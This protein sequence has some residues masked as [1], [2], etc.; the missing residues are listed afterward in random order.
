MPVAEFDGR[1]GW[2]YDGVE[3]VRSHATCTARPTISAGSSTRPIGSAWASCWTWSTTISARR[4][5]ISGQFSERATSRGGITPIGAKRSTSTARTRGPVREFFVANAGYWIDEF[6]LDGLRLD[7]VH[8]I[9]DDSTDHVLAAIAPAR[10][11]RRPRGRKTLVIAEN[12]F[13]ESQL[14]RPIERGRLRPRRGLERRLSSFRSRGNDRAQRILLRRLSRYAAGIDFGREVGLSLSRPVERAA[15]SVGAARRRLDLD[16]CQVRRFPAKPRSGRQ[17]A[18]RPALPRVDVAGPTSS[19]DGTVAP[20]ARHAAAC[21]KARNSRPRPVSLFR[22]S[23]RRTLASWCARGGTKSMRQFRRLAGADATELLGRSVRSVRRSPRSKLDLASATSP[24]RRPMAMHRDLLR[25]R[26]RRSESSPPSG[27]IGSTARC[28]PQRLFA[29][30][31]SASTAT[32]ACCWSIWAATASG[33]RRPSHCWCRRPECEWT[34]ALVERRSALWRPGHRPLDDRNWYCAGTCGDGAPRG[35]RWIEDSVDEN[36]GWQNKL[37]PATRPRRRIAAAGRSRCG[38]RTP[39]ST[40]CTSA[41]SSTATTTA[42]AIFA[43]L[44]QKLDYLQDLGVT[45]LWLLPFYPSPLRDDGYD[46]ADYTEINPSYGT[47]R[48]FKQFVREAHVRGLRVITE[49]VLNHTSDQHPWFQRARRAKPGSPARDFYVWSDTPEKYTRRADHFQGLRGLELGLGSAGQGL[50]LASLLF[51]PAR[52]EFRKSAACSRRCSRCST[53]GCGLGVDGMRL[54]A[55]PYLV[56]ARGNE[57]RKSAGDARISQETAASTSTSEFP[58]RMLLAEANQWPED[59]IAYFGDGDECHTAFHFPV[60][61]RL[62]MAIHME[63]RY[64]II[65]ILQQTPPIPTRLPVVRLP[66]QSRRADAR[67]GHRRGARLHVSRL[68]P[69]SAGAD[70]PGHSPPAGAAV[71]QRAAADRADERAVVLAPRH[72]GDL[73]R[74]RDRHGRQYLSGRSQRRAHSDAVESRPQRRLL[75]APT[76][77]SS[78][79]R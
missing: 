20:G 13:Q 60:M 78:T 65:D 42:S 45:A 7:A 37:V 24:C 54:D 52:S 25:L 79:L 43:G 71:G 57:L 10:A 41:R 29:R 72:A 27:P 66:A 46:I 34:C 26:A 23:R 36:H 68:R 5:I 50:L 48:D 30:D 61:P 1:F 15:S 17:F 19:T 6:H 38:T 31:T 44:T 74:R 16:A 64:P 35:T 3:S 75:R 77:S 9:L 62:F 47:L 8:A 4:A 33:S 12:E 55:V 67:N 32:I 18:A 69:R 56:R 28:S 59:A 22:R 2:G 51:A 63:D 53:I 70:Q 39:S 11:A 76:R 14:L 49:L 40:S 73:L 58:G 21:F